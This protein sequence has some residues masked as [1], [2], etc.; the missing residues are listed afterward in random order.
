M[1]CIYIFCIHW[2][3]SHLVPYLTLPNRQRTPSYPGVCDLELSED[4]L[5]HVILCHGV[6]HKVLIPGR[7]L[8]R[9]VLVTFFL[10]EK[11]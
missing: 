3:I 2:K 6:Y 7:A 11:K 4:V 1:Y 5:R 10:F 8:C 9:P